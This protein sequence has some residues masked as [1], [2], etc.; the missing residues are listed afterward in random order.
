[1]CFWKRKPK[2]VKLRCKIESI[3]LDEQ[4]DSKRW[5]VIQYRSN[6]VYLAYEFMLKNIHIGKDI[7]LSLLKIIDNET[8]IIEFE[9]YKQ[10]IK[11]FINILIEKDI[12]F[13]K[14]YKI[15]LD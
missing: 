2:R 14:W 10:D 11:D 9:G 1:M 6:P 4:V 7:S 12:N 3:H 15:T 8:M 13:I 5:W